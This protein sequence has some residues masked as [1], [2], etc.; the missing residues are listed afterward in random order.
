MKTGR[1]TGPRSLPRERDH[2]RTRNTH[3]PAGAGGGGVQCPGGSMRGGRNRPPRHRRRFVEN[4]ANVAGSGPRP[5]HGW[6]AVPAT[7]QRRRG[8]ALVLDQTYFTGAGTLGRLFDGELDALALPQQLEHRSPNRAAMEE[9]LDSALIADEA[10]TFVDQETRDRTAGHTYSSDTRTPLSPPRRK[11]AL[12]ADPGTD[13]PFRLP[14]LAGGQSNRQNL[15]HPLTGT[16][17]ATGA[18]PATE[19]AGDEPDSNLDSRAAHA[20]GAP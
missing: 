2:H 15:P 8:G 9:M 7:G 12:R 3:L 17:C 14:R 1:A 19:I 4:D 13:D 6:S 18:P 10:E 5:G 20:A 11:D 16:G